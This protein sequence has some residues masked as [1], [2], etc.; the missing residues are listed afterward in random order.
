MW[1]YYASVW[2]RYTPECYNKVVKVG[3]FIEMIKQ[4]RRVKAG[5]HWLSTH[6]SLP[7]CQE[8][9]PSACLPRIA[10]VLHCLADAEKAKPSPPGQSALINIKGK[11][12]AGFS[13]KWLGKD[14]MGKRVAIV[15]VRIDDQHHLSVEL[16]G[17][18]AAYFHQDG[19]VYQMEVP[20]ELR[21]A[22][23]EILSRT[24]GK[25]IGAEA[26]Q[27]SSGVLDQ[28]A[29]KQCNCVCGLDE[30]GRGTISGPLVVGAILITPDSKLPVVYDSKQLDR[31]AR[32]NLFSE[33]E[34]SGIAFVYSVVD[35][36]TIDRIGITGANALAFDLAAE[37]CEKKAGKQA[38]L[39][40]IDGGKLPLKTARKVQFVT[41]GESVSRAIAA[42]SIVA[43]AIHERLMLDL[44]KRYPQWGF[45]RNL[46]YGQ[47]GHLAALEEH[48]ICPEHRKSFNPI[49]KMVEQ[50]LV[51]QREAGQMEIA[52]L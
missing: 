42:A 23:S 34:Q 47:A 8:A 1:D 17:A 10:E 40:L 30:S 5:T 29:F 27:P 38:D 49:K 41:K 4:G 28:E 32:Q 25:F 18:P 35:A 51:R 16:G 21:A 36:Q 24:P 3:P 48:G 13:Y 14:E 50:D 33:I 31:A 39:L 37:A 19:R 6:K 2:R 20:P 12:G 43:T 46:G 44:H 22:F 26:L 15:G 52:G 45:D 11:A 9:V 7:L